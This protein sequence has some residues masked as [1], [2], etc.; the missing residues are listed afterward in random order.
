MAALGGFTFLQ[1]SSA[2]SHKSHSVYSPGAILFDLMI[3]TIVFRL[4]TTPKSKFADWTYQ[5]K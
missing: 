4:T 5:R 2:S 3:S 1:L